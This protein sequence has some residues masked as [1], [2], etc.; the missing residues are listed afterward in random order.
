MS[1]VSSPRLEPDDA[2]LVSLLVAGRADALSALYDRYAPLLLAVGLKV[3]SERRDVED[4]VHD[5]FMESWRCAGQYDPTRGSVRAW[6]VTRMRSRMLDRRKSAAHSRSVPFDGTHSER[7]VAPDAPS[8]DDNEQLRRLVC[9]LADDHRQI[10]E[11]AYFE[12]LSCSEIALRLGLPVGT[13]KSRSAAALSRLREGFGVPR[14][15]P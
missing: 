1:D 9:T 14:Q 3:I 7:M 15:Q 8:N 10:V 13:V 11:L 4:V 2:L 5:V 12:G 6:L